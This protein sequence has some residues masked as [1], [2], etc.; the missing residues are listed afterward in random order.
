MIRI[1]LLAATLFAAAVSSPANAEPQRYLIDP[2]H[3]F[4]SFEADHMGMSVWRGKFNR[5]RG[6][7]TLDRAA[8]TGS[9]EVQIDIASVDYGLEAMNEHARADSLLDAAKY[10]TATYRGTLKRFRRGAPTRVV[11]EFTLHGVTRPLTLEI[12]RFKCMPH[13]LHQREFCGA[14]ARASFQRDAFGIDA[15]KDYGFDMT[16]DLRIQVEANI[17]AETTP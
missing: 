6:H 12:V 2:E 3:T 8:K 5:S 1:L 10:P 17:A 9:V 11:G 4:P 14:D 7:I 13:P 15:G 16:V